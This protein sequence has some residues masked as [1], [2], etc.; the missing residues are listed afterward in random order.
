MAQENKMSN[1][2][3]VQEFH[4]VFGHP[5]RHEPNKN[6]INDD[7][8]NNLRIA[9]IEEEFTELKD[10]LKTR[11]YVEVADALSDILYVVYGAGAVYGI[12]LDKT[13][14]LVHES[15]MTKVCVSEEE[16]KLT[17]EE[18][19]KSDK[20]PNVGYKLS[21]NKK[22]WIVYNLD[23]GK[24]LKSINYKPVDLKEAVGQE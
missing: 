21:D 8:L 7:K 22:Y 11:N 14:K 1:F 13:F 20:Y 2:N 9:L 17:V 19:K 24:I 18:Y 3:M 23:N 12:D 5:N 16:A 15:N 4:E 6:Y 10:A